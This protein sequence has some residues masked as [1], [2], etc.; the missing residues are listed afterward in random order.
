MLRSFFKNIID[1]Y[2]TDEKGIL[3]KTFVSSE[4]SGSVAQGKRKGILARLE[5]Y[6]E[7]STAIASSTSSKTYGSALMTF[8]LLTLLIYFIHEY[9]DLFGVSDTTDLTFG[10]I[11][12]VIGIPCLLFDKPI[13]DVL[14]ENALTDFIVYEFF[15]IRRIHTAKDARGIPVFVGVVV[16]AAVAVL[17]YFMPI[18]AVMITIGV[19]AFVFLSF[20]SPEL[21]FFSS[22]LIMPYLSLIPYSDAVL[23]FI[24][25]VTVIS[26]LRKV[27]YGKRALFIEQYDIFLTLVMTMILLSGI[28]VKGYESFGGSV[29][30]V[31][32]SLGYVV[33]ANLLINRRISDLALNAFALSSVPVSVYSIYCG[34]RAFALGNA[35]E[36]IDVGI[37]STFPSTDSAAV[38]L[39]VALILSL[40]LVRQAK[41]MTRVAYIAVVV[42]DSVALVLSGELLAIGALVLGL[43]V[44]LFSRSR[45]AT[46]VAIIIA[47]LLPYTLLLL[48][49]GVFDA[50]LGYVPG[51]EDSESISKLWRSALLAFRDNAWLGI[52]IGGESFTEEMLDYGITGHINANNIFI[53]LG[54][55]AGALSLIFFVYLLV[56]R[57]R[58]R[59]VYFGYITRSSVAKQSPY[60]CAAL[61]CL[62]SVG[63]YNYLW[64]YLPSF[65]L[66]FCV[67]GI[68][69]ASLRI[70]KRENDDRVLYYE[71]T[72]TPD[73]SQIDIE[74]G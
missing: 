56:I 46:L 64:E 17:G 43:S 33:S 10:I 19:I 15:C 3:G 66:F 70:A 12:S 68:E 59:T 73:R 58:H 11:A 18:E 34:V 14:K 30:M 54:L 13:G 25:A 60:I 23:S 21:P 50:V 72:R 7:K 26:L 44:V 40:A 36:L 47:F 2:G 53:E 31:V 39:S 49:N 67:F 63:A 22:I 4:V 42:L 52:G 29:F 51:L 6:G 62:V 41:G 37:S 57:L 55:E 28:F 1:G 35:K 5:K 32:M 48:P 27:L 45:I 71:D 65:Y 9:F 74:I 61:L 20:L 8:G 69:S 38:F 16:G 24:I